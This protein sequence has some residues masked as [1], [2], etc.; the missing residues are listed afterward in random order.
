MDYK[1]TVIDIAEDKYDGLGADT[2]VE[3]QAELAF[4]A[5]QKRVVEWIMKYRSETTREFMGFTITRDGW[6]S[7]LKE[8]G[9]E[10]GS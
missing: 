1:D 2:L 3:I 5:G 9:V 6:Q 7:K 8:W 10:D 4:K